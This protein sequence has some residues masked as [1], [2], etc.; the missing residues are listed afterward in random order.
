MLLYYIT[1]RRQFPGSA[2]DQRRR[3][4]A[5]I[6]EAAAAG[7]DYV[8]LRERDLVPRELERLA[9]EATE[10]VRQ[11][12]LRSPRSPTRLL[13]N[14]RIDVAAVCADG[15]H[16]RADDPSA[17]D[18]R[19]VWLRMI[20]S[21]P[22]PVI[23]VSCHTP[24]DVLMAMSQGADF[25]VFAPVFE[26]NGALGVGLEQLRRACRI[27]APSPGVESSPAT[28]FPVLALGG[29]TVKNAPGCLAAGAAGIAGIRLFQDFDIT[30]VLADL[31]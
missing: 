14:S 5:K 10:I 18:A 19:M 17:G 16:L 8:Q 12:R 1:D 24:E 23:G 28:R 3:V 15:V 26:K 21:G 22:A 4:L 30:K 6:A 27:A 29:V 20:H 11:E 7:V 13:V 2:S 9:A 31:Q 25:A